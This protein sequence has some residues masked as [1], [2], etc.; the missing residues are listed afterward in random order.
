VL[1]FEVGL[2]TCHLSDALNFEMGLATCHLSDA[3]NFEVAPTFFKNLCN[4]AIQNYGSSGLFDNTEYIKNY[5]R[6]SAI[7]K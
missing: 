2:T 5:F 7:K 3:L 6:G 1:N 4:P